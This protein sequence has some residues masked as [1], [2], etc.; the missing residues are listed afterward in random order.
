VNSDTPLIISLLLTGF[1]AVLTVL[2]YMFRRLISQVD[3]N[4]KDI[5]KLDVRVAV[6]KERVDGHEAAHMISGYRLDRKNTDDAT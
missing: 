5:T 3:T 1:G 6:L 2:W 4:T